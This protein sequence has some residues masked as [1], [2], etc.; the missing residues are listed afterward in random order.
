M[1]V[2]VVIPA[3]NEETIIKETVSAIVDV[4]K[5]IV[6]IDWKMTIADNGS[7]DGT[8][9]VIEKMED[10]RISVYTASA[11]GKGRALREAFS[12]SDAAVIGFFDADL[13]V[14]PEILPS[15]IEYFK[16][17]LYDVVIGSRFHSESSIDRGVYRSGSSRV[18]NMLARWIVGVSTIDTQCGYKFMNKKGKELFLQN[19]ENTWFFDLEFLA[20]AQKAGLRVE[21]SP[22]R[23]TEFR[24]PLRK[25]KLHPFSDGCKAIQAM[26]RIKSRSPLQ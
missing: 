16:K 7:T 25:S 12:Q 4:L 10:S 18:F 23:W 22:V 6:D 1:K 3:Y 17:D 24:Y 5:G 13:S 15:T 20:N 9:K 21:E 11:K 26:F 8:R 14:D 2:E 19:K